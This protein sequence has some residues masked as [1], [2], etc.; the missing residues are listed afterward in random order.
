VRGWRSGRGSRIS[1]RGVAPWQ[2]RTRSGVNEQLKEAAAG[3][4]PAEEDDGRG[5]PVAWLR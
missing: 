1:G 4:V 5:T 2:R 3:G